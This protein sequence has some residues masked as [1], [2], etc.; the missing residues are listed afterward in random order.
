M[1]IFSKSLMKKNFPCI[2]GRKTAFFGH[3]MVI[4]VSKNA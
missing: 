3:F 1:Q 4:E 2:L